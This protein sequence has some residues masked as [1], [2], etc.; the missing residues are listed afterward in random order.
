M[1]QDGLLQVNMNEN[2]GL[3]SLLKWL[4]QYRSEMNDITPKAIIYVKRTTAF[5]C[6]FNRSMQH[7]G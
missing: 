1:C 2:A 4:K 5:G 3:S 7:I 6:E